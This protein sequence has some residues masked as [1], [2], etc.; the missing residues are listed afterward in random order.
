LNELEAFTT[1]D[2]L[3]LIQDEIEQLH[4]IGGLQKFEEE[5]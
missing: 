4:Q 2:Q 1:P 5:E 3:A